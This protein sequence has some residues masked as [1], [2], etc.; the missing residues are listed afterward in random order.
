MLNSLFDFCPDSIPV[1]FHHSRP[2]DHYDKYDPFMSAKRQFEDLFSPTFDMVTSTPMKTADSTPTTNQSSALDSSTESPTTRTA[3]NISNKSTFRRTA[4]LRAPKRNPA[5]SIYSSTKYKPTTIQRGISDE[6]PISSNFM[7][8]EEYDELPVKSHAIITPDLVPRS[9]SSRNLVRRSSSRETGRRSLSR[10][11]TASRSPS[12]DISTIVPTVPPAPKTPPIVVVRRDSHASAKRRQ[13][14]LDIKNPNGPAEYPLMKT[15]SLAAFL[16]YENDLSCSPDEEFLSNISAPIAATAAQHAAN[17]VSRDDSDVEQSLTVIEENG[18]SDSKYV[19][20][21]ENDT[22]YSLSAILDSAGSRSSEIQPDILLTPKYH[23]SSAKLLPIVRITPKYLPSTLPSIDV[24]QEPME[25]TTTSHVIDPKL[26]NAND[27][28]K[29]IVSRQLSDIAS[30]DSDESKETT[31]AIAVAMPVMNLDNVTDQYMT[32]QRIHSGDSTISDVTGLEKRSLKR[33]L[34]LNKDH[35][36]YDDTN[37]KPLRD[38]LDGW[39]LDK[40]TTT[41]P[42][43]QPLGNNMLEANEASGPLKDRS[44]ATIES[45][46]QDFDIA[47]FISSFED[48]E[49]YPIFK[50]YK[51]LISNSRAGNMKQYGSDGSSD[52]E[53]TYE[54][55]PSDHNTDYKDNVDAINQNG[56]RKSSAEPGSRKTAYGTTANAVRNSGRSAAD[57]NTA[58]REPYV[59]RSHTT[60]MGKKISLPT[61]DAS[62]SQAEMELLNSVHE[63]NQM[64]DSNNSFGMDAHEEYPY[65]RS[66]SSKHSADSAYSRLVLPLVFLCLLSSQTTISLNELIFPCL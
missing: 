46:F 1:T 39:N 20:E 17:E 49:Q 44:S 38:D 40:A 21:S 51:E 55:K 5:A 48:D 15:D 65:S 63:L 32:L 28:L 35:F 19:D 61:A 9:P 62:M 60:Q 59:D 12:R 29:M 42:P 26:I 52:S 22:E 27:N 33:Q 14:H 43:L 8:P 11:S 58:D 47:E 56:S 64:C 54:E 37:D 53:S 10:S 25:G 13:L 7:K 16:M 31:K 50:N 30:N 6:G 41:L 24:K 45:L 3:K 4:S 66:A 34:K 57:N 2:L 18:K 23:N 36:L